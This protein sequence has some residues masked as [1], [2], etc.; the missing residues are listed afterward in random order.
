MGGYYFGDPHG[1]GKT[2]AGVKVYLN[3]AMV[4]EGQQQLV[5]AGELAG[6]EVDPGQTGDFWYVGDVASA[7]G[8]LTL[9]VID[10]LFDDARFPDG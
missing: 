5:D 6:G 4:F 9:E 1:C 3:E 7:G 2:A 8:G 10:E